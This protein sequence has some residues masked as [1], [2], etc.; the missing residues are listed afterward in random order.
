V[1]GFPSSLFLIIH[2][3]SFPQSLSNQALSR[4][5]KS[6]AYL[7][8]RTVAEANRKANLQ[9]SKGRPQ[10]D[11][12]AFHTGNSHIPALL[13][14][15]PATQLFLLRLGVNFEIIQLTGIDW[16]I[17]LALGLTPIA[18]LELY[19]IWS[20]KKKLKAPL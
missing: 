5:W 6:V 7:K 12:L 1:T 4:F 20:L 10:L 11:N 15:L 13:M 14:Y 18:L 16:T 3:L 17:V 2:I 9:I 8:D 19:K